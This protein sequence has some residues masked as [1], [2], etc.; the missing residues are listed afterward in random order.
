MNRFGIAISAS[1]VAIAQPASA[2][3]IADSQQALI[4][5]ALPSRLPPDAVAL[6][7]EIETGD[8]DSLYRS[9]LRVRVRRIIQGDVRA[10]EIIL[11]TAYE[12]SCDDLFANGSSGLIV[13]YLTGAGSEQDVSPVFSLRG[14]RFQIPVGEAVTPRSPLAELRITYGP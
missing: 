2:C 4:H 10:S 3:L 11:R 8:P 5:S 13:G 1:I 9:G 6:D 14:D 7:V 12:T